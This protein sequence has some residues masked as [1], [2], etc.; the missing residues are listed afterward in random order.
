MTLVGVTS[1]DWVKRVPP[2][3]KFEIKRHARMDSTVYFLIITASKI[4]I[5]DSPW[6]LY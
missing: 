2:Y 5:Y 4:I 3:M 6:C 1:L